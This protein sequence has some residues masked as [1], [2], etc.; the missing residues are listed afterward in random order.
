[1]PEP[2]DVHQPAV[3]IGVLDADAEPVVV[4]ERLLEQ[5]ADVKGADD[6]APGAGGPLGGAA[7]RDAAAV[8]RD[9]EQRRAQPC[10]VDG[11]DED[12][13]GGARGP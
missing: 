13:V 1:M 5:S 4:A 11:V 2:G 10:D 8:E 7:Q 6:P 3:G 12:V 9:F